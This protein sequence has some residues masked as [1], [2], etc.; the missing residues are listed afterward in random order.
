MKGNEKLFRLSLSNLNELNP[1]E[2]PPPLDLH[3]LNEQKDQIFV[4]QDQEPAR[5]E[6]DFSLS[7]VVSSSSAAGAV[8]D[9]LGVVEFDQSNTLFATGGIA[10]KIRVYNWTSL[11]TDVNAPEHAGACDYFICTPAKLSGLRWKPQSSS[12]VIGSC[13]YDGVVT[14]YDLEKRVPVFERDEHGGRRV[15][16]MDYSNSDPVIGGSASDDGSMQMWDTRCEG[17][18]SIAIIRPGNPNCSSVCSVEFDP[19]CGQLVAV[20]CADRKA[21][22]FDI[23]K[24]SEPVFRLQ[25]HNKT[26][27][28]VRFI[29][30]ETIVTSG[31]DGCL[32]LWRTADQS[33]IRT[34]VGHVN[35]RRFVGL[36]GWRSGGLLSCGSENNKVFVYDKRWGEPI[37]CNGIG[38][39]DHHGGAAAFVS[40][41]CWRQT[42]AAAEDQCTLVAGGWN[43]VL[44]VYQGKRKIIHSLN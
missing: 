12:R 7:A 40:C 41:V 21:Y 35:T 19:S 1:S 26:V 23:R 43:G 32:K 24:L 42:T 11:S 22:G 31:T 33:L 6:W 4:D 20:G 39:D 18:N 10:R 25:G 15:W 14:E 29:D 37:W 8:S 9:T 30:N 16:A 34:Y 38:T 44:H 5:I 2:L 3:V 17:G 28:Y 13:D 36:S 27:A